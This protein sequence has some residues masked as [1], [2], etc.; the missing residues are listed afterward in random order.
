MV[1]EAFKRVDYV[2]KHPKSE[3]GF[4][5]FEVSVYR[6]IVSGHEKYANHPDSLL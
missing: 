4:D 5:E 6:E 2:T 1:R 3:K